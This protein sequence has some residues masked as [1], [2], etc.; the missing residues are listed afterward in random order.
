MILYKVH[1]FNKVPI[2]YNIKLM[3]FYTSIVMTKLC[4]SWMSYK[5]HDYNSHQ[6]QSQLLRLKLE[7]EPSDKQ[8][9]D[10]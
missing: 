3:F 8:P 7:V 6:E 5:S 10:V 1:L 9:R 2:I 4:K